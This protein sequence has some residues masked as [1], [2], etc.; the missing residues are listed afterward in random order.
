MLHHLVER[1]APVVQPQIDACRGFL[2]DELLV[3]GIQSKPH[4][5]ELR[6]LR[7][8]QRNGEVPPAVL[9]QDLE[10]LP[11][12]GERGRGLLPSV[13][14]PAGE[15]EERRLPGRTR[16]RRTLPARR[17]R[18]PGSSS[19]SRGTP[20]SPGA[21]C[22]HPYPRRSPRSTRLLPAALSALLDATSRPISQPR[23]AT[24]VGPLPSM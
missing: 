9:T 18:A 14:E 2:T 24:A 5:R 21:P 15:E 20:P 7:G 19:R 3:G 8:Q 1:G 6:D 16:S 17:S 22:L 12:I 13:V 4:G 11:E 10:L 23:Y